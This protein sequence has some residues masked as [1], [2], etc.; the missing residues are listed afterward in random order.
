MGFAQERLI[1]LTKETVLN[2]KK[3]KVKRRIK[4][5][6]IKGVSI[7]ARPGKYEFTLHIPSEYDYRFNSDKRDEI[8]HLLK[9]RYLQI[10]KENLPVFGH[11]K[12]HLKDVT[13]TEVDKKKGI[14]RFPPLSTWMKSQNL[15]NEEQV[16][17]G[18]VDKLAKEMEKQ[19]I[20]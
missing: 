19:K 2:I 7:T 12:D 3:D 11:N 13:T 15:L 16:K 5:A 18:S 10:N 14:N 8:I 4:I 9:V 1:V 20:T 17:G 6:S